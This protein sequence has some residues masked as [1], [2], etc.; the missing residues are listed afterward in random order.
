MSLNIF[1]VLIS[2]VMN[3]G[4]ESRREAKE[5][6][7]IALREEKL[8]RKEKTSKSK[9]DRRK[10]VVERSNSEDRVEVGR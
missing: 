9:K 8:K 5:D 7:K 10:K 6:R 2:R 3:I 1:E 4:K